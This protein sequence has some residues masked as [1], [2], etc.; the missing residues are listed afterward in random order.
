MAGIKLMTLYDESL[1]EIGLRIVGML[2]DY[3]NPDHDF[4]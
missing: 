4:I 1:F 2:L 3:Q